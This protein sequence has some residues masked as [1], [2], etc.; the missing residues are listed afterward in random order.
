MPAAGCRLKN[1]L[2]HKIN[3]PVCANTY[4]PPNKHSYTS[5]LVTFVSFVRSR[6]KDPLSLSL[7]IGTGDRGGLSKVSCDGGLLATDLYALDREVT[8]LLHGEIGR[9]QSEA[10]G[11]DRALHADN[12]AGTVP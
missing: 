6:Y 8:E 1:S 7:H 3:F 11:L 12:L 4:T 5:C 10:D 9:L 2:V